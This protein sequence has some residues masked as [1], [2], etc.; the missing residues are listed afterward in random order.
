MPD[1]EITILIQRQIYGHILETPGTHLRELSRILNIN[2]STLRY[3]VDSLE[4]KGLLVSKK[5]LNLKTYYAAGRIGVQDQNITRLLH[6]K[7][8]RDIIVLLATSPGMI[9]GDIATKLDLRLSTLSKY[10]KILC[11]HEILDSKKTG[12]EVQYYVQDTGRI[13]ELL[14]TYRKSF[15]DS[16]VDNALAIYFER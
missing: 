3:H 9:H 8:F 4:K 6:Q 13:I 11:E 7:R 10:I 15:W 1:D 5:D 14:I 16:F 2:L 12:N